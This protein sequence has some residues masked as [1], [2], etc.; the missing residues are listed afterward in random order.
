MFSVLTFTDRVEIAAH[1]L[2]LAFRFHARMGELAILLTQI[3]TDSGNEQQSVVKTKAID[4][5]T[6]FHYLDASKT[7]IQN[8][9]RKIK[10]KHG[11]H[12]QSKSLAQSL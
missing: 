3:K 11:L 12:W 8:H 2:M 9:P 4:K 6:C 1:L 5:A 10:L 7:T